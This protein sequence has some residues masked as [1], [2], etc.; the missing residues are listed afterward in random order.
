MSIVE[1]QTVAPSEPLL[2][3]VHEVA[4]LTQISERTIWRL[5][6]AELMPQP[7]RLGGSVRWRREEILCWISEGCPQPQGRD[8]DSRR[9]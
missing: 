3:D 8:N 4:R 1:R 2:I 7:V 5:R 9:K 6:S